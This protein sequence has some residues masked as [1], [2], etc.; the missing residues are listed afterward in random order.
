MNTSSKN[1]GDYMAIFKY[2]TCVKE[3]PTANNRTAVLCNQPKIFNTDAPNKFFECTYYP[4][5]GFV[6][7]NRGPGFRY[8]TT[9]SKKSKIGYEMI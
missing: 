6:P 4:A 3:C 9:L 2:S 7:G 8:N 5:G 1:P